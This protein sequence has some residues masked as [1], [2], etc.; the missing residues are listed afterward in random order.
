M[1]DDKQR[2]AELADSVEAD[3]SATEEAGA[4][5]RLDCRTGP[6][7]VADLE[8]IRRTISLLCQPA[9]IYELRARDTYKGTVF[10]YYDQ[11]HREEMARDAAYCSDTLGAEAT[12][13][14]L[15]R[16]KTGIAGP[17]GKSPYDL[18]KEGPSHS[19]QAHG[20]ALVDAGRRAGSGQAACQ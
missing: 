12:Y 10:G 7:P 1:N 9:G 20:T 6:N 2:R 8:Q 17:V 3:E 15:N 5:D 18:P 14:T 16:I 13:L 19:E 4:S 11:E